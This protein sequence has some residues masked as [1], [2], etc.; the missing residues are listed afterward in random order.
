MVRTNK[1]VLLVEGKD[2]LYTV[3]NLLKYR[4]QIAKVETVLNIREKASLQRLKQGLRND[5]RGSELE[6]LGVVLDADEDLSARW[7]AITDRLKE[8]DQSQPSAIPDQP[9]HSGTIFRLERDDGT[10][11]QV[12][13]WLMPNNQTPGALEDFLKEL[14]RADDSLW[15]YAQDCV[16]N[17]NP[18]ER[19]FTANDDLKAKIHTWL[20]WQAE[21]GVPFGTA[22]E[23]DF[24]D[25][26]APSAVTLLAWLGQ[27]FDLTYP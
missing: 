3:A 20:A 21:P 7:A 22:I 16:N 9:V 11:I 17:I 18:A 8:F 27:L 26:A 24:L 12:G 23:A 15:S 1:K 6:R 4:L 10:V 25:A 13:I 2:D 5:L 14:I 19:R